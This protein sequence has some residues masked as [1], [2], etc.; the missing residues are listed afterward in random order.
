MNNTT[1]EKLIIM[2]PIT[3]ADIPA[4][5]LPADLLPSQENDINQLTLWLQNVI[6]AA[7]D[8]AN[9]AKIEGGVCYVPEIAIEHSIDANGI[10]TMGTRLYSSVWAG[11]GVLIARLWDAEKNCYC[12]YAAALSDPNWLEVCVHIHAMLWASDH[13]QSKDVDQ[14]IWLTGI[15]ASK[16]RLEMF[17]DLPV[18]R[19]VFGF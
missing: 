13:P 11:M 8:A 15:E 9:P 16:E 4:N 1:G 12:R 17:G 10:E 2:P 6:E 18:H 14:A 5:A 7:A 3:V 19:A